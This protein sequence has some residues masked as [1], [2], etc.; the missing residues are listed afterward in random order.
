MDYEKKYKEALERAKKLGTSEMPIDQ[1]RNIGEQIFTELK[2]SKDEKIRK[3]LIKGFKH[4][5]KKCKWGEF[6]TIEILDWLEK[7]GENINPPKFTFDDILALQC[8]M[9]A[10]K[11]VQKDKDLYEQL[12]NL[13]D[14]LHDTY[15]LE[16]QGEQNPKHLELK[17]GHWYI[18]HRAYCCRADHLTVKEGERFMCEEDGVVK[19]FVIKYPEKYFKEVCAPASIEDKQRP[20]DDVK[21]KFKIGDWIINN[22]KRIAV[23]TQI[24][25]IEKYGYA[26]SRGYISFDKVKTD[27]RLWI[28]QDAKDG[29]VLAAH[30]TIVLFKKIEGQNIRCYCTYHYIGFNPTF[31][32]GTLQNKNSYCPATK[33]QRD[34]L[35]QKIKEAGYEWDF[36]KKQLRK[37]EQKH[38]WSEED[39]KL[40]NS[41]LWHVKNSCG[42]GGKNS[43]EFD[44]Y[45]WLKSLKDRIFQQS[46]Q[47][48]QK[49]TDEVKSKFKVGDWIL[50]RGDHF[51]GVRHITKINENG[52]Y[53]ERNGFPNGI[54]PFKHE[55]CMRL[56]TIQDTKDGDILASNDGNIIMFKKIS[57]SARKDYNIQSHCL[58]LA[59]STVFYTG[60]SYN[61]D[62]RLF[63]P[64]TKEQCDFLFQKMHEAGY[65]W[66]AEKK[67]LKKIQKKSVWSKEDEVDI[68]DAMWK[69]EQAMGNLWRVER[70]LESLKERIK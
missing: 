3:A 50:Y 54:I 45:N 36:E 49:P 12:E 16:K 24:L 46:K 51:E 33:E 20:A 5:D 1:T 61:L 40:F 28:I 57:N 38:V 37:I 58:V 27:C 29:D 26:T 21:S 67:E 53:I 22:D 55:I 39:E 4:Y 59:H 6:T 19:G 64:A 23:P 13:H 62:A 11:K 47:D 66:D 14:R 30:E 15:W 69:I 18:C 35:F 43:G 41:A 42:N 2:E 8:A 70:W 17:A 7:Q 31:Y 63:H 52:Y 60:G 56:W 44:V 48:E 25:E 34:L 9:Y 65:E 10:A 68:N 32:V